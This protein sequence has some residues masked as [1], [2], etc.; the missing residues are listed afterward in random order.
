MPTAPPLPLTTDEYVERVIAHLELQFTRQ[1][2]IALVVSALGTPYLFGGIDPFGG[3]ADCSGLMY[4]A[5][6]KLGVTLPRTTEAE[7][8]DL[9]HV[10]DPSGAG[11]QDGDLWE[12]N[13]PG[14]GGYPP[15]HVGM[16]YGGGHMIDDPE[17]GQV[18][19]VQ[20]VPDV[21]GVI[22][23][24][25]YVVLPFVNAPPPT[26]PPPPPPP[27]DFMPVSPLVSYRV[28]QTDIFQVSGSSVVHKF[29][30]PGDNKKTE[31]LAG[32]LGG[33]AGAAA[34][35]SFNDQT[36]G[37]QPPRVVPG[38]ISVTVEDSSGRVHL[39]EQDGTGGSWQH[40]IF[41]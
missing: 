24:I 29:A 23:P 14:D 2:F 10:A 5:A 22:W 8:A 26:P 33:V 18:V 6:L 34:V 36:P 17:T 9:V 15:Q 38:L 39:F 7:W 27:E 3:G 30:Q 1:N 32:P 19:S 12:F 11:M 40:D 31:V 35:A 4:W 16:K 28:G 13:V 37:V 20:N 25:G 41:P 21:P